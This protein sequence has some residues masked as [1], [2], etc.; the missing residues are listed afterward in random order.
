MYTLVFILALQCNGWGACD[1]SQPIK[2]E[3]KTHE[4]CEIY[5]LIELPKHGWSPR[6]EVVQDCMETK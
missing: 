2:L 6:N 3:F 1:Y 5:K 4:Q